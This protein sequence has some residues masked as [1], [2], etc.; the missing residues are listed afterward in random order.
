MIILQLEARGKPVEE[1]KRKQ[2]LEEPGARP[3]TN[4]TIFLG[5]TSNLISSGVRE[6][7]RFLVQ[8]NMV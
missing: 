7:L 3:V 4:C 1:G 2:Y 8:N 6:V 5:F